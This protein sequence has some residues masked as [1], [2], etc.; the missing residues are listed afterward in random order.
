MADATCRVTG[1]VLNIDVRSGV[2]KVSGNPYRMETARV[3]V[4][5]TG[6]A[7]VLLPD[8]IRVIEGQDVDLLCDVNVFSGRAQLSAVRDLTTV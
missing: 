7:D 6:V 1:P 4:L 5:N 2:A 3:L 8:N